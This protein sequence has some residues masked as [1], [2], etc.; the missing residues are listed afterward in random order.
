MNLHDPDSEQP[1]STAWRLRLA[2]FTEIPV[3][4]PVEEAQL[5]HVEAVLERGQRTMEKVRRRVATTRRNIRSALPAPRPFHFN[6]R[7]FMWN[8]NK[9]TNMLPK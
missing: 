6:W 2:E 7:Q 9:G 8:S 5:R 1:V 4:C 3:P